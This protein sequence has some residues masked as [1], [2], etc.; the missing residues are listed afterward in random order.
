MAVSRAGKGTDFAGFVQANI[1]AL[2]R[3]A[4]LLTGSSTSAE[5]LVQDAFPGQRAA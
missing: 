4:Y 5:D 1:A 3:T 2:L